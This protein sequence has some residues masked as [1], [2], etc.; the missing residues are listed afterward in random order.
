[1]R[2]KLGSITTRRGPSRSGYE[3]AAA[4]REALPHVGVDYEDVI[5]TLEGDGVQS[6]STPGP[7][8]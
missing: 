5:G 3:E 7:T 6:L 2:S 4:V 1:L 8:Y